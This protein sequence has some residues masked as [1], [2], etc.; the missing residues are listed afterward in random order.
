MAQNRFFARSVNKYK[1]THDVFLDQVTIEATSLDSKN[2][3]MELISLVGNGEYSIFPV[4]RRTEKT[5]LI[6]ENEFLAI[7]HYLERNQNMS[8]QFEF[9]NEHDVYIGN[10]V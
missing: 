7:K 9:I 5:I 10:R 2:K 1:V 3:I 4:T 8:E 6:N